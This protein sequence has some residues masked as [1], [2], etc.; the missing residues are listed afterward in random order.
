MKLLTML[1]PNFESRADA[2]ENLDFFCAPVSVPLY[3]SSPNRS[4]LKLSCSQVPTMRVA[5]T[6]ADLKLQSRNGSTT[7]TIQENGLLPMGRRNVALVTMLQAALFAQSIMIGIILCKSCTRV[8][9]SLRL[10]SFIV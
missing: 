8:S 6:Q 4:D 9:H 1:I 2:A 7:V 5:M 10:I 3:M